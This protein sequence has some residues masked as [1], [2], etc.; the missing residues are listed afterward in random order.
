VNLRSKCP[1]FHSLRSRNIE[2]T[3]LLRV[4]EVLHFKDFGFPILIDEMKDTKRIVVERG[5]VD[6]SE[7]KC[8]LDYGSGL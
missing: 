2:R 5:A 4:T 8:E 7:Y 3:T 1:T 6:S